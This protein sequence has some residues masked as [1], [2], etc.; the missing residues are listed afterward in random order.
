[1]DCLGSDIH[2][3]PTHTNLTTE[4]MATL[5]FDHWYCENGLPLEI[6]SD[7]DKLFVSKFWKA[8]HKL[9]GVKLAMSLSFHPQT[10]GTSECSNKTVNQSIRYHV[11][12]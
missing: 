9:T 4:K 3:V 11:D 8:L 12:R 10:D 7:H 5:F 1:M 2:I 6:I